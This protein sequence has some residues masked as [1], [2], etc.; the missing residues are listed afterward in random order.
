MSLFINHNSK[1]AAFLKVSS[2]RCCKKQDNSFRLFL[3]KQLSFFFFCLSIWDSWV[4]SMQLKWKGQFYE[5][6]RSG[7][8]EPVDSSWL[9][10]DKFLILSQNLSHFV[11]SG[12]YKVLLSTWGN[13]ILLSLF[14]GLVVQVLPVLGSIWK[15]PDVQSDKHSSHMFA[16]SVSPLS[17][18]PLFTQHLLRICPRKRDSLWAS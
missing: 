2:L 10:V 12:V 6:L 8:P 15:L 4:S 1:S 16:L 14:E 5:W 13:K 3:W 11:S 7:R 18:F 9:A 17:P